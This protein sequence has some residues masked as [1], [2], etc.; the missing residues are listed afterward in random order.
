[1]KRT[2]FRIQKKHALK[3]APL[4][5]SLLLMACGGE[6]SG[7]PN[8]GIGNGGGNPPMFNGFCAVGEEGTE[9]CDG[10]C[11]LPEE[12]GSDDCGYGSNGGNGNGNGNSVCEVGEDHTPDC[13]GLY[14]SPAEKGSIDENGSP[15]SSITV[16]PDPLT[17]YKPL[18]G[19]LT[20]TGTFDNGQSKNITGLLDW[21]SGD[22][23]IATVEGPSE[24]YNGNLESVAVASQ[25]VG[26]TTMTAQSD[27]V[28]GEVAVSVV[29]GTV[30]ANSVALM[31]EHESVNLNLSNQATVE[32]ELE[33]QPGVTLSSAD[34]ADAGNITW[35]LHPE[36]D[37]LSVDEEGKVS[38]EMTQ[39]TLGLTQTDPRITV[40][41]NFEAGGLLAGI[42]AMQKDFTLTA[43]TVDVDATQVVTT[44]D[45]TASHESALE[46]P[47]GS[48][49][50]V[51]AEF[52]FEDGTVYT[53]AESEHVTW[54]VSPEDSG[55]TVDEHGVVDTSGV[56][57]F[58]NVVVTITATGH[59][60]F[61]GVTKTTTLTI[62][63]PDF[64]TLNA[65]ACGGQLN[66]T[67][68]ENAKG[69]CLK[70]ATNNAGQWF[71]SSPSVAMTEALGYTVAAGSVDTNGG[72]TYA[73][74]W[75]ETGSAGPAGG[76]FA[77]FEQL[78]IG[79]GHGGNG[80][81]DRWCQDLSAM[82]F[83]GKADWRRPSRAELSSLYNDKGNM[84]T[85]SGWPTEGSYYWSSTA[86]GS[87]YIG[88]K[89]NYGG[90][91]S[92][93][94]SSDGYASCVSGS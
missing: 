82:N 49:V 24:G 12:E 21:T 93:I 23:A 19:E 52:H 67:D 2:Q 72:R 31:L 44:V 57:G 16:S 18:G 54:T 38:T 86:D 13:D 4:M 17:L 37:G 34:M 41:A 35:Q 81:F 46:V 68:K 76:T 53:T 74:V 61:D 55:V 11:T 6:D 69:A 59:G 32:F 75:D 7:L 73:T 45:G 58:D 60:T 83:G 65:A 29:Q 90:T 89:L 20:A 88:V 15:L 28:S 36:A 50:K 94:P 62:T 27:T 43:S 80:Q 1:M 26:S 25:G 92:T 39:E 87:N 14:V 33:E 30:N 56:T 63:K 70:I 84:W 47:K 85:V 77:R 22:E 8:Q 71:T 10:F 64:S 42:T 3:A 91:F 78:A 48:D 66:D 9:D 5:M 51:Q 40:V 79:N